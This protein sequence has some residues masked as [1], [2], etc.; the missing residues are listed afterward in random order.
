MVRVCGTVVLQV[1]VGVRCRLFD[2]VFGCRLWWWEKG[3]WVREREGEE[4]KRGKKGEG[5]R[6]KRRERERGDREGKEG[7]G[8]ERKRKKGE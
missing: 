1:Y 5:K 2:H 6:G 4:G 3:E 7:G 8:E